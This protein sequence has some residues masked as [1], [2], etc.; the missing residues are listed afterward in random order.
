MKGPFRELIPVGQ[1]MVSVRLPAGA[2]PG[3]IRL[4]AANKSV[5]ATRAD[6]TLTLTVPSVLDHEIIAID[7]A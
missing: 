5:K 1:Q 6:Q 4:L 3:K 7:L 2:K